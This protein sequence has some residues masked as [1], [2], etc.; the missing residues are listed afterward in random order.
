M[1]PED[2]KRTISPINSPLE[3]TTVALELCTLQRTE[4]T[5]VLVAKPKWLIAWSQ[6]PVLVRCS[7]RGFIFITPY[8]NPLKKRL[9]LAARGV[10][11][12]N[13][14][15]KFYILVAN[16][17]GSPFH[18]PKRMNIALAQEVPDMIVATDSLLPTLNPPSKS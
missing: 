10:Y 16:L 9:F 4:D 2:D 14:G 1:R 8:D 12:N 18:L 11:E 6:T 17:I 15:Q 3:M 7:T 5:R 13:P